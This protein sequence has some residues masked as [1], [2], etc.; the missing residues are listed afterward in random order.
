[1]I[2]WF[3]NPIPT[4]FRTQTD[5][6]VPISLPLIIFFCYKLPTDIFVENIISV[7]N[8]DFVFMTLRKLGNFKILLIK[9]TIRWEKF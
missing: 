5:G 4:C 2:K 3:V 1:M 7:G 8:S 6:K 9:S